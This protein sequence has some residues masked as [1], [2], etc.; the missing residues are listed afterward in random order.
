[1]RDL[2]ELLDRLE[3]RLGEVDELDEQPRTSD[4]ELLDGIDTLHRDGGHV[5]PVGLGGLVDLDI[6]AKDPPELGRGRAEERALAD[7]GNPTTIV[8]GQLHVRPNAMHADTARRWAIR[9]V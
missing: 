5:R 9:A 3:R 7:V 2:T 6:A 1:M 8:I 4:F